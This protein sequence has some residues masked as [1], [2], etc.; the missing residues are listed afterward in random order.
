MNSIYAFKTEGIIQIGE[1]VPGWQPVNAIYPGAPK[2]I[3][4]NGDKVLDSKDIVRY[5]ASPNITIG[6][7]NSLSFKHFDLGIM[8]YSQFGA[9]GYNNLVTWATP[10]NFIAGNQSG[11]KELADVWSTTNTAGTLPGVGYDASAL[12]LAAGVNTTLEKTD[13]IRCR[14]ITLGYN[15]NLT[16]IFKSLKLYVDAQNPFIITNYKIADPEVEAGAV[17]GGAAPYPMAVTYS[18]GIKAGF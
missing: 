7:G 15:F 8:F 6:F 16:K 11:I 9:W 12:G 13:F 18:I 4:V 17:K 10:A 1:T 3:D 5:D 14:N 2:F